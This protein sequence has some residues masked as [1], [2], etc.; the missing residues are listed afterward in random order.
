MRRALLGPRILS[1]QW[2]FWKGVGDSLVA[3]HGFMLILELRRLGVHSIGTRRYARAAFQKQIFSA[4]EFFLWMLCA[5][6]SYKTK[7]IEAVLIERSRCSPSVQPLSHIP[8]QPEATVR[9]LWVCTADLQS[10]GSSLQR[11][12]QNIKPIKAAEAR[13]PEAELGVT[14]PPLSP[15]LVIFINCFHLLTEHDLGVKWKQIF[16]QTACSPALVTSFWGWW[17]VPGATLW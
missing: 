6:I 11:K 8:A 4:S 10:P 12:A 9:R 14:S 13:E 16:I 15:H 1:Y 5:I 3:T 2:V 17:C 7:R